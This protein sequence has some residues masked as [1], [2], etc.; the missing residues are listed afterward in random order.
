MD[1]IATD[2]VTG[3]AQAAAVSDEILA[4]LSTD[5]KEPVIT[6]QIPGFVEDGNG[7]LKA[8]VED[9]NGNLTHLDGTVLVPATPTTPSVIQAFD[10]ATA[11]KLKSIFTALEVAIPACWDEVVALA[12]KV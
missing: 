8:V 1:D 9:A 10:D 7:G 12:K 3:T 5:S 6:D 4:A 2:A 11:S